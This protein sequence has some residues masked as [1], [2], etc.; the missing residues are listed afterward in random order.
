MEF[1]QIRYFLA[2]CDHMNFTRAAEACSVSQPALSVAI[3]KLEAELG[4]GSPEVAE[5]G[6]GPCMSA[7]GNPIGLFFCFFAR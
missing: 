2:A 6:V 5:A 1:H 4:G 7:A 3:Q